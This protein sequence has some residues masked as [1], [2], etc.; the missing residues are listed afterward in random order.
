[1]SNCNHGSC[2]INTTGKEENF[3]QK[4]AYIRAAISFVL[5]ITGIVLSAT[6]VPFFTENWVR[7]VW[8]LSAYI[9][10][11]VPVILEAWEAMRK[12]DVFS[13]FTLMS[14]ATIGAFFIGEYP[15]GV[16]VM[17][18]YAVG[19]LFQDAAVNRAKKSISALLTEKNIHHFLFHN[20]SFLMV[21]NYGN[22][23]SLS[24]CKNQQISTLNAI[25]FAFFAPKKKHMNEQR[26]MFYK[27]PF[28]A[29]SRG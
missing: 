29:L 21:Q 3:S 18:F 22:E 17:L 27:L 25:S 28:S 1:M 7:F 14:I 23:T 8:Y 15:E 13:E 19:E 26:E 5:L 11:G 20:S 2:S 12:I 9:P 16:A 6:D 4:K 24:A 10:V